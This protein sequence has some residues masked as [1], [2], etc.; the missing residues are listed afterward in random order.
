MSDRNTE[1]L[2]IQTRKDV[3]ACIEPN[4]IGGTSRLAQYLGAASG[5]LSSCSWNLIR[6][7]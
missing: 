2:I 5:T 1:M 6:A 7:K 3:L 4:S